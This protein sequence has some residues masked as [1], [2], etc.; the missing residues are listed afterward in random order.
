MSFSSIPNPSNAAE[1]IGVLIAPGATELI[2][3]PL[4]P[5]SK[6][7]ALVNPSVNRQQKVDILDI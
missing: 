4:V 7:A 3:I 6:A 5:Y 1:S 2:R